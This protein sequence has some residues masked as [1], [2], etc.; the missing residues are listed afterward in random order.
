MNVLFSARDF[1]LKKAESMLRDV[2]LH[3]ENLLYAITEISFSFKNR[4]FH[5]KKLYLFNIYAQ[6]ID[7]GYKIELPRRG[8][9]N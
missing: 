3:F 5:C 2:S 1:D 9:S 6:N 4:K 8:I 7:C